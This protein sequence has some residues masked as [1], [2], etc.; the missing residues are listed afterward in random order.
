ML[1]DLNASEIE[2]F[3]RENIVGR[4]GCRHAFGKTYVVP[5]TYAYEGSAV[6]AHSDEGMKL[7]MMRDNPTYRFVGSW[8]NFPI[9]LKARPA[10]RSTRAT[11]A[12]RR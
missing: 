10:K 4:I 1:G 12:H 8:I 9:A 5:I 2:R 7:H 6:Y 3:L 11:A